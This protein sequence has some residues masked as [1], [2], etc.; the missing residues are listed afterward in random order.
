VTTA[1]EGSSLYV[2]YLMKR[3]QNACRSAA[4]EALKPLGL[5]SS[6]FSVLRRLGM[7]PDVSGADLARQLLV[8]AQSM[9]EMLAGLVAQGYIDRKPHPTHGRIVRMRL[10]AAGRKVLAK[11]T[12]IVE[13]VT[14]KMLSGLTTD[15]R[16]RFATYLD[17]CV[18]ALETAPMEEF[19]A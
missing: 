1:L 12:A 15:E 13:S 9:N 2:A 7:T 4:D 3:A 10:T 11:G 8:T 19:S 5:S 17:R 18:T 6:Q 16:R 14:D